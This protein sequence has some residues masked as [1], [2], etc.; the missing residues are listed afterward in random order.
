M[1]LDVGMEQVP[2]GAGD[3]PRRCVSFGKLFTCEHSVS[4]KS[5]IKSK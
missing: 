4:T 1:V 3:L 2:A 5:L